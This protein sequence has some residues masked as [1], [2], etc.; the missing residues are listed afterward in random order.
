MMKSMSA[1]R[2]SDRDR[3]HFA[4]IAAGQAADEDE[5]I[6]RALLTSPGER[7]IL[8]ARLA[9]E[10]PWTPAHLAEADAA[11]DGQMELARRRV[12]RGLPTVGPRR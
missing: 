9:A 3:A 2:A 6:A 8:G 4:A 7:M 1:P 10:M 12:A 5:R 11:A